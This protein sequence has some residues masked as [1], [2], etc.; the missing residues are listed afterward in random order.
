MDPTRRSAY[1]FPARGASAREEHWWWRHGATAIGAVQR[2]CAPIGFVA[3]RF[4]MGAALYMSRRVPTRGCAGRRISHAL[5]TSTRWRERCTE[6]MTCFCTSK[7]TSPRA[8]ELRRL[9]NGPL[10][11][12]QGVGRVPAT[13]SGLPTVSGSF[14]V[15]ERRCFRRRE[16]A[17]VARSFWPDR[18]VWSCRRARG[19]LE[20]RKR[21]PWRRVSVGFGWIS[22]RDRTNAIRSLQ[23]PHRSA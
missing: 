4:A 22:S 5:A 16:N 1:F 9:T 17:A 18:R 14:S 23:H 6:I 20:R 13:R 2:F 19:P 15:P 12:A 8:R 10:R 11:L 21:L 7:Q 3:C